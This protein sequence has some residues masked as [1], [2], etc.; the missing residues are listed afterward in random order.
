MND[1]SFMLSERL[2]EVFSK[3][4]IQEYYTY[5]VTLFNKGKQLPD[6]YYLFCCPLLGYNVI[7]F[8]ES[9]FY[10][11]R[12]LFDKERKLIHYKNEEEF[13]TSYVVGY[14]MEKLVL[15]SNFDSSLDFFKTRISD[16]YIRRIKRSY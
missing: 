5:P 4:N 6:K 10:T 8:S 13:M 14:E 12:S 1:L 9:V 11:S 3:F 7:N 15:N 2:A 16:I